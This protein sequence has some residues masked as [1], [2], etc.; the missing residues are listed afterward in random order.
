MFCLFGSDINPYSPA[1]SGCL[2]VSL[3]QSVPGICSLTMSTL[4]SELAGRSEAQQAIMQKRESLARTT[5]ILI[6]KAF[7]Y[8]S[9][10]MA[11]TLTMYLLWLT[12]SGIRCIIPFSDRLARGTRLPFYT[13]SNSRVCQQ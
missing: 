5:L 3:Y 10:G 6:C 11:I 13:R 2:G 9:L 7:C 4:E 1:G 8:V 12:A